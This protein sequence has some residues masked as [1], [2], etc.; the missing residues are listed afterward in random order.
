[1]DE[2]KALTKVND[3]CLFVPDMKAAIEFYRDKMKFKIKFQRDDLYVIFDFQG[4]KLTL[5][6][7]KEVT[8]YAIDKK[9]I[10]GEGHHFMFAIKVETPEEVE[11]ISKTLQ[12]NGVECITAPRDYHWNCRAVYFKDLFGNIWEIF[13]GLGEEDEYEDRTEGSKCN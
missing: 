12:E 2:L 4:T 9:Y 11:S 10:E 3:I 1:M 8:D 5:W 13:A 6:Q 7:E